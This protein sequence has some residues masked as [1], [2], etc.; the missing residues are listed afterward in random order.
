MTYEK[1]EVIDFGSIAEHTYWGGGHWRKFWDC[2]P[3]GSGDQVHV[4]RGD[5]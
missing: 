1:P 3:G 5:S 2:D 4:Y